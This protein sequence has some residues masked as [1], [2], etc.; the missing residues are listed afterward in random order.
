[1][2][3]VLDQTRPSLPADWYYDPAHYERELE[4]I[5]YRLT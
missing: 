2:P 3:P 4:A 1:M 5:W